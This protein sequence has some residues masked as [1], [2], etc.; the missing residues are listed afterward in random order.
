MTMPNL[1]RIKSKRTAAVIGA[2]FALTAGLEG[3]SLVTY[4]DSAA[5]ATICYGETRGVKFGDTA[6]K[7][8]CDAMLMAA[9]HEY[10]A[11]VEACAPD[12]PD[13]SFIAFTSA[14]YNIG[15]HAFCGSSMARKANARDLRGA[16]DAL[17]AWNKTTIGGVK[18]PLPGLTKRRKEE[19]ALCLEGLSNG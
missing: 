17:L 5:I 12:L 7:A 15:K 10:G 16:C 14:T 3:L 11:A 19:R 6:T 4:P 1:P 18:V 9:M 8:E 2:A 13:P